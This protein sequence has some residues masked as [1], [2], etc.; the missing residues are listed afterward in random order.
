MSDTVAGWL[1]VAALV[2]LLAVSYRPLGDHMAHILTSKKHHRV[3]RGL[4]K[5]MGVDAEADQTWGTYLRSVFALSAVGVLLLYLILRVQDHLMMALGMPK[6]QADLAYNTAA[7]FVTNTN[8]QN[9]YGENTLG[10]ARRPPAWR[11]RTSSPPPSASP[12]SPR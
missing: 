5:V 12:S 2:L 8:W 3:E 1:Q 7:S 9:Y 10:Y 4:Y 11:S 6:M